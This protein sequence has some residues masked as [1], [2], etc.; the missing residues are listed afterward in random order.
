MCINFRLYSNKNTEYFSNPKD[1]FFERTR[2]SSDI[3]NYLLS[4]TYREPG[5]SDINRRL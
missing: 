4:E 5:F 1:D 2:C 3:E